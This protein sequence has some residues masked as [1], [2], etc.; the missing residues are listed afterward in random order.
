[1][2]ENE[3]SL[4]FQYKSADDLENPDAEP[5]GITISCIRSVWVGRNTL[6]EDIVCCYGA[7]TMVMLYF[8]FIFCPFN[9]SNKKTKYDFSKI[10]LYYTLS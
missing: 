8:V 1:M 6:L 10:K 4:F 7:M 2:N 9:H 3:C 5:V